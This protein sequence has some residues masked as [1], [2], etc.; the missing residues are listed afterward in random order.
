MTPNQIKQIALASG[1][2]F[3]TMDAELLTFVESL[4]SACKPV[5]PEGWKLA[6]AKHE[7]RAGL[8]DAMMR[9][10]YDAFEANSQRGD[11]E[12]LNAGYNAML[13]VVPSAEYWTKEQVAAVREDAKR[14]L[15]KLTPGKL[16]DAAPA[17]SSEPVGNIQ[18][19]NIHGFHMEAKVPWDSLPIGT[20]LY[21]AP[22]AQTR[23]ALTESALR[24]A[25]SQAWQLGQTYWQQA[26]S[27]SYR[28]QDKS[29]ATRQRYL[30]LVEETISHLTAAQSA[31]GAK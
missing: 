11:F 18:R 9:A 13:G 24:K 16:V 19:D 27:D 29:D 3:E 23:V 4:L 15:G 5:A 25:M 22:P 20:L 30:A 26:D 2:D 10:F 1:L 28:Q 6:P 31:T 17:Q 12:R 8:T 21:A 7:G 14:L